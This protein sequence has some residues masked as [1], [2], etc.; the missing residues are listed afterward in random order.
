MLCLYLGLSS[1]FFP[2]REGKPCSELQCL[3]NYLEAS[4]AGQLGTLQKSNQALLLPKCLW[5][6]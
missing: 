6:D 4:S 3:E 5:F 1:I 2:T